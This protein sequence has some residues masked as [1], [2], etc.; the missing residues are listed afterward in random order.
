M[1]NICGNNGFGGTSTGSRSKKFD[2]PFLLPSAEYR[3][4]SM[5]EAMDFC[6]FLYMQNPEYRKA[7]QRVTRH[8]ITDWIIEGASGDVERSQLIDYLDYQLKLRSALGELGDDWACFAPGTKVTTDQGVFNIEE[9]AGKTVNVLSQDGKFRSA[10]FGSY[11]EQSLME[12]TLSDDRKIYATPEHKWPVKNSS[13]K[14][15]T[16]TTEKLVPGYSLTRTVAPRPEKNGDYDEGVR[17]GFVFGGGSK[18]TPNTTSAMFCGNKDEALLE[19]FEDY[20]PPIPRED[21]P[22]KCSCIHGLPGNFKQLPA[23]TASSSYWLGFVHGFLA[24]DGSVD[25]HGC[26]IL[27]QASKVTLEAVIEQLPRVGMCAG[28]LRNQ[29]RD[30]EIGGNVYEDHEMWTVTLLKQFMQPDDFLIAEHKA[31]FLNKWNPDSMHGRNI[32]IKSVVETGLASEVFCCEEPETHKFVVDNGILTSNCYGNAY[33]RVHFPFKRLLIKQK[34]GGKGQVHYSLSSFPADQVKFKLSEM[35]YYAPDP[36]D[37]N[38]KVAKFDFV[39]VKLQEKENINLVRYDPRE[40]EIMNAKYAGNKQFLWKIPDTLKQ[41]V[42]SGEIF[43]INNLSR[44][45]LVA[46][47]N[48]KNILF[49][50]SEMFHFRAPVI[51]GISDSDYGLPEPIAN[52]R[53]LYQIQVYRKIDEVVGLD[54][55]LPVRLLSMEASN[56]AQGASGV[57][58]AVR[59]RQEMQ[60]II[61]SWRKDRTSMFAVPMPVNYQE[62]GGAGKELTPKDLI[63]Y[64]VNN[65]LNAMGYPAELYNMSLQHQE[66]PN[67]VRLF[68]QTFWFIHEGYNNFCRWVL[69]KIN[70]YLNNQRIDIKLARP[71]MAND[72]EKQN[73][74]LQLVSQGELPRSAVYRQLGIEDPLQAFQE[75]TEEEIARA[76][77][78]QTAE[79]NMAREQQAEDSLAAAAA[80]PEAMAPGE[81]TTPGDVEKEAM[82]LAQ[83]WLAIPTDGERSKAM[84]AMRT[85]NLDL[86]A[87]A[88]EFMEQMRRE[89]ASQGR[90]AVEQQA[91][92][93][94]PAG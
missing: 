85:Q 4:Q 9:L 60:K 77:I 62:M 92:Q 57:Y 12:V 32:L 46:I 71:S 90:Q 38:G 41:Q 10:Q 55:M 5:N 21:K 76:K 45:M 3:P 28:P 94:G 87:M 64:Q 31:K 19:F 70:T 50:E 34:N 54:Y 82:E 81:G 48:N 63:E 83:Q 8:F 65:M 37:P 72:I 11:G 67:A 25:T 36:T 2:D 23:R 86:Y 93:G 26:T 24:A 15:V 1:L 52:F 42:Q 84:N 73:V 35:A 78:T 61:A 43:Q 74:L 6:R 47:K 88:K 13:G 7:S 66:V 56:N 29:I 18:S 16:L 75:R 51:S 20:G 89:G 68:E 69:S 30:T 80:G 49:S 39:D 14:D 91:Q 58:D 44:K 33:F 17:H 53:L 59:W 79:E 40:V 27:S 22:Y